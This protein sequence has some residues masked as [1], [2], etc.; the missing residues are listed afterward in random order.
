MTTRSELLTDVDS[1]MARDDLTASSSAGTFLRLAEA[2][3]KRALRVKEMENVTT[4]TIAAGARFAALPTGWQKFRA[5]WLENSQNNELD[6]MTPETLAEDSRWNDTGTPSAYMIAN[7][8]FYV[9]PVPVEETVVNC[10]HFGALAPLV[11]DS[12]TNDVLQ[13]HYD[14]YLFGVLEAAADFVQDFELSA[15]YKSKFDQA[16][17]ELGIRTKLEQFSGSALRAQSSTI[18]RTSV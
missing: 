4:I 11:N 13:E 1:F 7:D 9:A 6:L 16:A 10:I 8:S 12:D 14:I 5:V 2:K 18:G 17:E 3:I 15:L